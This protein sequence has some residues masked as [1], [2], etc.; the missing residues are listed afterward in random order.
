LAGPLLEVAG[1]GSLLVDG[2]AFDAA[3]GDAIR[4]TLGGTVRIIGVDIRR[5]TGNGVSIA[6]AKIAEILGSTIQ[7]VGLDA[8]FFAEAQRVLV[9]G[10]HVRDAGL[11]A[12]LRPALAA[13][14]AHRTESATVEGNL[15]ERSAYIGIRFGGDARIR[16][17]AV[18][19]SCLSLSDCAALY[20]WR[21]DAEDRRP[22]S[23][24]TGNLVIGVQGDT[25][26]KL[27]VNDWFAGIYLDEFSNDI[28]VEGNVV[29]GVNQGIYLHNAWDVAVR[30][31]LV[32][33]R[34]RTLID[35]GE[36]LPVGRTPNR[37]AGN[38]EQRGDFD[39]RLV[40]PQGRVRPA[41]LGEL[42]DVEV[43]AAGT[44]A[45]ARRC[46]SATAVIPAAGARQPGGVPAAAFR[47][48]LHCR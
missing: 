36:R 28:T 4:S 23:E 27:G 48:V 17:N 38:D 24:V 6:G 44:A 13:I 37:M 22:H 35:A 8:V 45:A 30:G 33:A 20:T 25:S 34:E 32:A 16:R 1:R 3:G 46:S 18:L 2:L 42:A 10:N 26:V 40:D 5:A 21:N 12:G 11:Y 29:V 43:F 14:N 7:D 9:R 15:V 19:Q 41:A 47:G 31:N 39:A